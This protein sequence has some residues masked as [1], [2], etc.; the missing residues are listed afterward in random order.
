V[1]R[2][3]R[4]IS[5][6]ANSAI[7]VWEDWRNGAGNIDI[8]G[9]RVNQVAT[10]IW[11]QPMVITAGNQIDPRIISDEVLGFYVGWLD[12]PSGTVG[13]AKRFD[14]GNGISLGWPAAGVNVA[15]SDWAM[16]ADD[17]GGLLTASGSGDYVSATRATPS[18]T[19][20]WGNSYISSFGANTLG[21]VAAKDGT[22]GMEIAWTDINAGSKALRIARGG[23]IAPYWPSLNGLTIMMPSVGERIAV[24]DQNRGLIMIGTGQ[25]GGPNQDIWAQHVSWDGQIVVEWPRPGNSFGGG[26]AVSL[27]P[28]DQTAPRAI[29]DGAG[30]AIVVWNDQRAGAG[31]YDIY[32]QRID[33]Y[34]QLGYP[35]PKIAQ[36]SDVSSDQ[37][38]QVRVRWYA[39]YLD[40]VER[41][42]A[43][44]Q[45]WRQVP[46]AAALAALRGG[47][48]RVSDAAGAYRT[49]EALAARKDGRRVIQT[50]VTAG[51]VVY[52]EFLAS[53]VAHGNGTYSYVAPTTSDSVTGYNPYTIFRVDAEDH[54]L[55]EVNGL[56]TRD[57]FAY[58]RSAPDSGYSVDNL[59][60][61]PP[62]PFAGT[63]SAGTSNLHWRPNSE[64]D[65]RGYRLY[66]GG[67]G[68][69]PGP[70]NFVGEF[71]DTATADVAGGPYYYKLSAI[72][73]HGN[74]SGFTSLL[75]T[76]TTGA[77][78]GEGVAFALHGVSP[79]PVVQGAT[80]RIGLPRADRVHLAILDV[81]GRRVATV[82]QGVLDGGDQSIAWNGRGDD[83]APVRS[84]L[85]VVELAVSGRRLH[86]KMLVTR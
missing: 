12:V 9:S 6:P 68:F 28:Q 31:Q 63:Y 2:Q 17:I 76:G 3:P 74:E 55:D 69:V 37:G 50:S 35:E 52:W 79:N 4:M 81:S 86:Q 67:A 84:G 53:Q 39:S 73:V 59:A 45:V 62:A 64:P 77:G 25:N 43:S 47:A 66:R 14:N 32:A 85:Y 5:G 49:P 44:Y 30:G 8:W 41:L 71:P 78:P 20:D 10:V 38:G 57:G 48:L 19:I 40:S 83:G 34:G 29:S 56:P 36:V 26:L 27:A 46:P 60:P 80:I 65:V 75:P 23:S 72:D 58:W 11:S 70:G 54:F 7:V 18:G 33:Y 51:Q 42:V 21:L 22:G 82:F 61:A 13:F 15:G 16:V 24:S 1:Q